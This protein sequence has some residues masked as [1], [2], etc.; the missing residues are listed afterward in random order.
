MGKKNRPKATISAKPKTS[1]PFNALNTVRQ[2]HKILNKKTRGAR[3]NPKARI[4]ANLKRKKTLLLELQNQTKQ[5]KFIDKR[6]GEK[7]GISQEEKNFLRF[8]KERQKRSA[9]KSGRF[10]LNDTEELTHMGTSLSE[11]KHIDP[12]QE[13]E[14]DEQ[15]DTSMIDNLTALGSAPGNKTKKELLAELIA[16]QKA[17]K[18]AKKE[19]ALEQADLLESL[20]ASLEEIR[21]LGDF[22]QTR[23]KMDKMLGRGG[24]IDPPNPD[25]DEFR[26]ATKQLAMD[27]RARATERLKTPEEIAKEQKK[28][29]E[30]LEADRLRRMDPKTYQQPPDS[31]PLQPTGDDL[32]ESFVTDKEKAGRKGLGAKAMRGDE[33]EEGEEK[34]FKHSQE[35][36]EA[37]MKA[38]KELPFVFDAPSTLE[39][40][41]EL[42][43]RYCKSSSDL[44]QIIHRVKIYNSAAIAQENKAKLQRFLG[45]LLE[46]FE[47]V[48]REVKE[49]RME[50]ENGLSRLDALLK[51]IHSLSVQLPKLAAGLFRDRLQ[52]S[53]ERFLETLKASVSGDSSD[54]DG[55]PAAQDLL[56]MQLAAGVFPTSDFRHNVTVPLLHYLG[57]ILQTA[58]VHT[59]NDISKALFCCRLAITCVRQSKRFFPE[60]IHFLS[61]LLRVTLSDTL[62]DPSENQDLL[63]R[64]STLPLVFRSDSTAWGCWREVSDEKGEWDFSLEIFNFSAGEG[65][66]GALFLAAL[67]TVRMVC[68]LYEDLEIFPSLFRPLITTLHPPSPKTAGKKPKKSRKKKKK[69]AAASRFTHPKAEELAGYIQE[70]CQGVEA[71]RMPLILRRERPKEIPQYAP[72]LVENFQPGMDNEPNRERS[73]M[74]KLKKKLK[75][76]KKHAMRALQKDSIFIAR[77]RQRALRMELQEKERK[78]K[79]IRS[80]MEREMVDT[81]VHTTKAK[82]KK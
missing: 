29:L 50:V 31:A 7:E 51:G 2:K 33:R 79:R 52:N 15:L 62:R 1:N 16:K 43:K 69:S 65:K 12:I 36:I 80:E 38:K 34:G 53:R 24:Y 20:D 22:K 48:C 17:E 11:I 56:F 66:T 6:F 28:R 10:N 49:G 8:Q 13:E 40:F 23:T 45:V 3:R 58:P 74:R 71:N 37:A 64:E 25:V 47:F 57:Q 26:A 32:V 55:F 77:E 82:R 54:L 72:A 42:V 75:R 41:R 5:N 18:A 81:N 63:L 44:S 19:L 78:K 60:V 70:I 67:N 39:K 4:Q 27:M 76:E 68:E 59:H 30:K 35:A 61:E 46:Y 73:E 14:D 9:S 21:R